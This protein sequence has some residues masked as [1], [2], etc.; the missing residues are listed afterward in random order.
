MPSWWMP[1]SWAKALAPTIALLGW[2]T[3]PVTAE[4]RREARM[5]FSVCTPVVYGIRSER[6]RSAMTISS[7]AALPARSPRPLMVHST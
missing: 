4:T 3:K 6:V 7:M 2:T 5:M 1:D